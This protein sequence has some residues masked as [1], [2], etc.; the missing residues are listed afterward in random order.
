[1]PEVRGSRFLKCV[2]KGE[3]W[4]CDRDV[5]Y[6]AKMFCG[7]HYQ[8]ANSGKPLVAARPQ[9]YASSI[10]AARSSHELA[11]DGYGDWECPRPREAR[12][13]CSAHYGQ[14]RGT[15]RIGYLRPIRK[16]KD[17]RSD[18]SQKRC[19]TCELV[20]PNSEF[21]KSERAADRLKR[22][23]IHCNWIYNLKRRFNISEQRYVE[24]LELQNGGCAICERGSSADGKRLAIDHFHGC[25]QMVGGSCG[26]CIRGLLCTSCNTMLGKYETLPSRFQDSS[27]LNSYISNPPARQL[28]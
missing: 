27:H 24:I 10:C 17:Y 9:F 7:A 5:K 4:E 25:C 26:K 23:C 28:S 2:A 13:W 14:L 22:E 6:Y 1:M 11:G 16:Y 18:G 20:R 8:Q 15:N 19:V 12:E 21:Y 3:G